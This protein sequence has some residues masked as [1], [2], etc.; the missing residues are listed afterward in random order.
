MLTGDQSQLRDARERA[1]Q[2]IAKAQSIS[3]DQARARVQQDEQ[4]YRQAMHQA[5]QKATQAADLSAKAVSRGALVAAIALILG[6]VASCFGGR[7]GAVDS[8]ITSGNLRTAIGR[9]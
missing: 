1:V 9:R 7:A 4:Q 2:A 8:T 5:K 3:M 6:A